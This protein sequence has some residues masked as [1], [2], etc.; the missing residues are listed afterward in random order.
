MSQL[1]DSLSISKDQLDQFIN[2]IDSMLRDVTITTKV[3]QEGAVPGAAARPPQPA[4]LSAANLEKQTQALKQAQNRTAAKTGQPP[5]APTTSQPPFQFGVQT[6]PAG[7]P[8]Y[9]GEQRITQENLQIP[10]AR[11]KARTGAA[12]ASP[13]MSQQQG[14]GSSSPQ[15][16]ATSPIAVR[17]A[18][19]AKTSMLM[20]PEPGC[21]MNSISF[22]TEEAL[23][24]HRQE[25][26]IKP[27]ENPYTFVQ[28][29]MAAALGLDAQGLPPKQEIS[30]PTAPPMS[31]SLSKQGQTPRIKP[32]P[33]AAQMS[34]GASMRR[35]GSAAGSKP[36]ETVGTPGRNG[37]IRNDRTP[38]LGDGRLPVAKQEVDA[39]ANSTVDPQNL[40]A[41]LGHSLDAVTGNIL[42]DYGT[43]RSLTPNDTP[44]SSK[45]SGASEPTSDIAEGV[46]LD[47]DLAWQ[48]PIDND[49]LWDLN[50][51]NMEPFDSDMIGGDSLQFPLEDMATD[52]SKPFQFDTSMFS[53][54]V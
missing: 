38:R 8:A 39:W 37:P 42:S 21:E 30:T 15:V 35:Q 18:E 48:Q 3:N 10:P 50:N 12:Q 9:Y 7:N 52:F 16:K 53:M 31:S 49:L 28:E 4:P 41:N 5:A 17:K 45:D 6:S 14:A 22:Q 2:M 25:E 43:Y 20:C 11:K 26:H 46:A 33:A 27:F 32:D 44:E 34:R 51:I 36:G 1:K 29:Q 47:I 40:F 19:P 24:A 13:P 54:D 23:N